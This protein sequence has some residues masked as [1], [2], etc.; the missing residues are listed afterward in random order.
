[1]TVTSSYCQLFSPSTIQ[2][3]FLS[4]FWKTSDAN[5]D[6]RQELDVCVP[7]RSPRGNVETTNIW[8][9][10]R[11]SFYDIDSHCRLDLSLLF[12]LKNSSSIAIAIW[13]FLLS[14]S[15][16]PRIST[17]FRYTCTCMFLR[18]FNLSWHFLLLCARHEVA[19]EKHTAS[20]RAS[21]SL[22]E[23]TRDL[24]S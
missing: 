5:V 22:R 21:R 23:N 7:K 10:S 17:I 14:W 4:Y 12:Y 3:L 9:R 13:L 15:S 8:S 19:R 16:G 6:R 2:I 1:M 24:P 20:A 18:S 11:D